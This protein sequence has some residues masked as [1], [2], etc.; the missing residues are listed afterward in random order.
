MS[1][2]LFVDYSLSIAGGSQY[3][4]RVNLTIQKIQGW[5]CSDNWDDKDARVVCK[6]LGY[7]EGVAYLHLRSFSYVENN[8]PYW[9]SAVNCTG[10]ETKL[11]D[12][13]HVEFGSVDECRAHHY[14][15]VVCYNDK[16]KCCSKIGSNYL[17]YTRY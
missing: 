15:G 10:N 8:G 4:G 7:Q 17:V 2:F 14:A 13:P 3:S 1:V 16:G 12:C 5:I 11:K 9:T 6:E